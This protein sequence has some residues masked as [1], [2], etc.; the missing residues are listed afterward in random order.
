MMK[1]PEKTGIFL[2]TLFA[3]CMTAAHAR[4]TEYS[5]TPGPVSVSASL[6]AVSDYRYR[7]LSLSDKQPAIQ[8]GIDM[9]TASGFFAGSWASNIADHGGSGIELN[10]YGGY[11]GSPGGINY[12]LSAVGYIYPGGNDVNYYELFAN[13]ERGIGIAAARLEVAYTPDQ[14]NIASDS[15]Y[16]RSGVSVSPPLFPFGFDVSAG[17]ER[18]G[19]YE[20]TDW[21]AGISRSFTL[22]RLTAS[23]VDA[24]YDTDGSFRGDME[25]DAGVIIAL[26]AGL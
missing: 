19:G 14:E 6:T 5:G 26:S 13:I 11:A 15:I 9:E 18:S 7:G 24:S 16:I 20:K 21:M 12:S 4:N 3:G 2:C 22:F 8:G 17:H 23:Y 1:R 10:L 25:S